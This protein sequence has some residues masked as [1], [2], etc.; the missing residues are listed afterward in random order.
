MSSDIDLIMLSL[1]NATERE[2]SDWKKIFTKADPRFT[3]IKFSKPEGSLF[4][5]IETTWS[6]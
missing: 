3:D 1:M 5:I 6:G 2:E 4:S